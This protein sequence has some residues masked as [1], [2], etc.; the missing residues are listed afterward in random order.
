VPRIG[1]K[2]YRPCLDAVDDLCRHK[3]HVE[4]RSDGKGES[5]APRRMNMAVM[6]IRM[7]T[8]VVEHHD[9]LRE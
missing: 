4:G 9:L 7:F 1:D 6:T 3:R 2:S 5:E 8:Y